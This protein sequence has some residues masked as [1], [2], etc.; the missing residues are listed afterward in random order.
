MREERKYERT[1]K[2]VIVENEYF[3]RDFQQSINNYYNK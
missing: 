2:S 1:E 3:K